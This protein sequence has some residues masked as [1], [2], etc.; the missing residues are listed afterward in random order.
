[1]QRQFR[2]QLDLFAPPARLPGISGTEREKAV[3]L[4]Q[5]LLTEAMAKPRVIRL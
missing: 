3:G 5:I 1:M 4:L 2:P